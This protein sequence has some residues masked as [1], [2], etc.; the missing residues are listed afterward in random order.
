MQ[1]KDHEN[2]LTVLDAGCGVGNTLIPLMKL[3]PRLNFVAFDFSKT[4][5]SILQ[6]KIELFF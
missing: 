6:V 3:N 2:Q 4:A 1:P 5:V